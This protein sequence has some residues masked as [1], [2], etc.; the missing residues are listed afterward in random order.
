MKKKI[1]PIT[2]II[3]LIVI[4]VVSVII[5]IA[6]KVIKNNMSNRTE[7]SLTDY[8][9][10]PEGEA[11]LIVD[12]R[13]SDEN[14]LIRDNKAYLPYAVAEKMMPRIYYDVM[15]DVIVYTTD[16]KKYIYRAGEKEYE[17]NKEKKSEKSPEFIEEGGNIYVSVDFIKKWHDIKID[18]FE[19]PARIII[20]EDS[21][22]E[23]K[24]CEVEE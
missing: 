7:I 9:K 23:Y 21:N 2:V 16:T 12:I 10:V 18:I 6:G 11:R 24:Y 14:A 17:V 3:P 15:D 19:K 13:K 1:I 22:E 5:I 8:Y 4:A 20:F